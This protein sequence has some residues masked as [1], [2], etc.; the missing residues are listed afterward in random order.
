MRNT[1]ERLPVRLWAIIA[2]AVVIFLG[3]CGSN[4]PDP[5][6]DNRPE[7]SDQYIPAK[8]PPKNVSPQSPKPESTKAKP[9]S[10]NM[11][12]GEDS[13]HRRSE[14]SSL[15]FVLSIVTTPTQP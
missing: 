3:G 5:P 15:P 8:P 7:E 14:V 4:L 10:V 1:Q 11:D 6:P 12:N 2:M 13:G 9:N